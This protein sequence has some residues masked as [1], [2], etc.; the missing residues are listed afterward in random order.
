MIR[1]DVC[2]FCTL[3][4]E[5]KAVVEV[6]ADQCKAQFEQEFS[7]TG[8]EY[9]CTTIHNNRGAA[10][11]VHLSWPPAYGPTEAS[12]HIRPVLDE[13]RPRFAAMTGICAGDRRKVCLGDLVV[14]DR[15]FTYDSGK[16]VTGEDGRKEHLHDTDTRQPDPSVLQFARMFD[17]WRKVVEPWGRPPS[18]RQQREW[19][20]AK[21][22]EDLTPRVD[23]IPP[24]DLE[25][26][27]PNWRKIVKELQEGPDPYL[28]EKRSLLDRT[29]VKEHHYGE[30]VFPFVDPPRIGCHIAP[31]ASGSAV[32]SDDPFGEVQISVRGTIAIDMEGAVFYRTVAEFPGIRSLL[33]KGVCDYADS[34]KD[35]SYHKYAS[36]ASAAY[37]LQFI[38]EYVTTSLMPRLPLQVLTAE[39]R[40]RLEQRRGELAGPL[41]I[42][43]RRIEALNIDIART[44]DSERRVVLEERLREAQQGQ[45][46]IEDEVNEIAQKLGEGE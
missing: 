32:R 21:L 8:R 35:D 2:I 9:R 31:I 17:S 38:R 23:D 18:K 3:A 11:T 4:E 15:A 44:L 27:V 46:R 36:L 30:E 42:Y 25:K 41:N 39:Q 28:S 37:A 13:V 45:Q 7:N 6:F 1:S 20:L 19:L 29:R 40:H 34:D 14:A 5:V 26:N 43:N 33:V 22:L 12:L 10:L 16:F 24:A